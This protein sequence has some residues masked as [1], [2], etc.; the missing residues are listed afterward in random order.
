MESVLT[1]GLDIKSVEELKAIFPI[2]SELMEYLLIKIMASNQEPMGSM[3]FKI[4][5]DRLNFKVGTATIGRCLKILDSHGYTYQVSNKGRMLTDLGVQKMHHMER[6]VM[7]HSL[8]QGIVEASKIRQNDI[9]DLINLM[10]ARRTIECQAIRMA[11]INADEKD[12]K[13]INWAL[14]QH[15]KTVDLEKHPG[16][17]GL[18]F[19]ILI[20]RAS[21]NRFMEATVKL[22]AYEERNIEYK[23]LKLSTYAHAAAYVDVHRQIMDA[24]LARDADLAEKL[25][26]DHFEEMINSLFMDLQK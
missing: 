17:A 3:T 25:M 12:L 19:H 22:L 5:L 10:V 6:Q 7:E 24:L 21:K 26:R 15:K 9:N 13:E 4:I 20:V 23:T 2:Q 8:G 16:G 11:A 1:D 14:V 18:D